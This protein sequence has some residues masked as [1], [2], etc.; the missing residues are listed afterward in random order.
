MIAYF[1][2]FSG[3]SG[4]MTLGALIHL[5]V[6]LPWLKET[7][8]RLPL[9][10][11]DITVSDVAYNGIRAKRV[12]VD[13][14]GDHHHR[15][16]TDIRELIG[17]SPLP[18]AVK[19]TALSVFKRLAEAEAGVHGCT[20]EE[21]HFHEVGA[22]DAIVDV[23]GT[24]L[25]LHHLGVTAASA[26]PVPTGRGFVD[27]RHGRLPVP[28]PATAALL[29]GVPVYGTDIEFE[30]TTPT[31]AAIITTLAE[32]FGPQPPMSVRGVGY[33]AGSRDLKPGPN[34]LRVMIGD[35]VPRQVQPDG[36]LL[37][38]KVVVAET[39]IDDMNPELFEFVMERLFAEGALDV[40]LIPVQMKK[41]RPAV[42]VQALCR[43]DRL[44]AVVRCILTETTSL[45][46]RCFEAGRFMLPR[47]AETIDTSFGKV[48]VKRVCSPQGEV[49]RVPEY[50]ECRRIALAHELPIRVVY[51][52]VTAEANRQ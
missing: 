49:R 13:A 41:N 19:A 42:L 50:A 44:Q 40:V 46:V 20:P 27:C 37:Q 22:V 14:L 21:V 35:P 51:E 30:L 25:G 16:Y 29:Q 5:G 52:R 47:S 2:C 15:H 36:D 12:T 32:T 45:G 7:I 3:I 10:G 39:S 24:A 33:G 4:D 28:A 8:G 6:P 31:G 23:V 1:D 38:D 17:K 18:D 48:A 9:A 26:A 34:L 43:E 11:F